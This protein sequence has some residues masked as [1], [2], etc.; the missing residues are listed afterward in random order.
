MVHEEHVKAIN[1]TLLERIETDTV[2]RLPA[3]YLDTGQRV[4]GHAALAFLVQLGEP[5]PDIG[6]LG[7]QLRHRLRLGRSIKRVLPGDI[8]VIALG[9]AIACRCRAI[10]QVIG[11]QQQGLGQTFKKL[12]SFSRA[13]VTRSC[14][15]GYLSNAAAIMSLSKATGAPLLVKPYQSTA[16]A[17]ARRFWLSSM[18]LS[19]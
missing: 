4:N 2:A 14:Q 1:H 9:V 5:G 15:V 7:R 13:V 17:T 18:T 19:S 6:Q 10:E 3:Q 8:Q 11:V 16:T 12:A